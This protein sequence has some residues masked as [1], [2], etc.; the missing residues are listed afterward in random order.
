M[1]LDCKSKVDK[2]RDKYGRV[3]RNTKNT[4]TQI[5]NYERFKA[6]NLSKMRKEVYDVMLEINEP[7]H[8][9]QIAEFRK[10]NGI[11]EGSMSSHMDGLLRNKLAFKL[12]Y[13]KHTKPNNYKVDLY[14]TNKYIES[15]PDAPETWNDPRH[16]KGNATN[17]NEAG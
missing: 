2:N 7:C 15:N 4:E 1:N 10:Y 11:R 17:Q 16:N 14:V 6:S 3:Q 8:F 5:E 12:K 9:K 13:V